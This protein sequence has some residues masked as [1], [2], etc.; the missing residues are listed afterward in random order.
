[1]CSVCAEDRSVTAWQQYGGAYS[2]GLNYTALAKL[3]FGV[4]TGVHIKLKS[5]Y[6]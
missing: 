1:M 6:G 2:L 4:K 5:Y 3:K